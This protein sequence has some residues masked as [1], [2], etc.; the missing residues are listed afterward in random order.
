MK[1]LQVS[2]THLGV[3]RWFRGAP[4]G[5]RRGDD[6]LAVLR[7]ALAPALRGDV[8]AVVHSGDLFDRSRPPARVVEEARALLAEVGRVTP[9]VV[10]PG[11]HDRRG[12]HHHFPIPPAGVVIVDAP[13]RLT[14]AGVEL[15]LVPYLPDAAA[16]AAAARE[17]S[18]GADLLVAHQAFHGA[19]VPGHTFRVGVPA[20]TVGVAHLPRGVRHVLCGHVHPRQVVHVGEATVVVAGSTERT[21]FS[22]RAE[23]KGAVLWELGAEVTWRFVDLPAR[24]MVVVT[25]E[26]DLAE[27]GAGTLVRMAAEAPRELDEVALSRGGWVA[28]RPVERRQVGLF[29][30]SGV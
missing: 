26:A 17:V 13:D 6:H 16:W 4:R 25:G 30:P 1:L 20:E 11:N 22:E 21:A 9:V 29:D 8:D 28:P 23:P 3:D 5:W 15:A 7:T 14:V 12:L 27:V 10:M 19:R 24:P 2:D 18:D